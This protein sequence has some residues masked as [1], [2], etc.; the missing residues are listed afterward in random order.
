[1]LR[2]EDLGVPIAYAPLVLVGM[3]AVYALSAY[4]AGR[5]ADRIARRSLHGAGIACL[6][7]SDVALALAGGIG[8][9]AAGVALWGLHMGLTQGLLAAM[10]ARTAPPELR[11]TAFGVFNLASGR[12]DARRECPRRR[13][14]A[15]RRSRRDL[16]LGRAAGGGCMA[17][18]GAC[19]VGYS[20]PRR[21]VK[22]TRIAL[23]RG[24]PLQP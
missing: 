23:C 1:V 12:G 3:S 24:S 8:A 13:P 2:A 14:V 21:C 7:A 9:L 18:H 15:L 10:V 6:I 17:A 20:C 11:G 22:R 16:R 4:P 19:S 5:L